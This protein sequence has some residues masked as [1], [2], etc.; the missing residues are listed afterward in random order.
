MNRTVAYLGP[1]GTFTHEA[2]R[3]FIQD[4]DLELV[5]YPSIPDVLD[6]VDAG[7][8]QYGVVPVENA[9]E[10]SVAITLDWLIH[11]VDVLIVG[12]L[13]YPI[14]QCL[15]VHPLQAKNPPAAWTRILSHPQ[16]VAQCRLY[17]RK[18][19]PD[20]DVA[21]ADSTAEAARQVKNRFDEPWVAIGTRTAGE[22]YGLQVL[23][24]D[25]QDHPN[26]FTR[27][28]VVGKQPLSQR[29]KDPEMHKT[30]L[31]VTLPSDYPGAL[32]QVLSAFAW[33]QLNLCRIE[34]RP[35]KKGLGSYHFFIDVEKEWD[36]V[37]LAGAVAEI[38]AL[39]C[40]VRR[41][42]SFPCYRLLKGEKSAVR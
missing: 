26:N 37:L 14:A 29:A 6:A 2:T 13:V 16:A 4:D 21:F 3:A 27:F 25:V 5:E 35:T 22:L 30:S 42:G 18:H 15:L 24:E 10:G 11:Q 20:A 1:A 28:I 32:H 34:S 17:L 19:L 33:R 8:C 9:I 39:G 38:E 12:E 7:E 23:A 31:L 36:P 41:L 40:H